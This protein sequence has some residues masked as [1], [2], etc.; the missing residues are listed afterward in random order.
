MHLDDCLLYESGELAG[1]EAAAFERHLGGCAECRELLA[2]AGA[3]HRWAAD[4]AI[5]PSP[6]LKARAQAAAGG[7]R[8]RGRA[9]AAAYALAGL[10]FALTLAQGLAPAGS[11]EDL[12]RLRAEIAR[13]KE[14][15]HE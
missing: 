2:A 15:S 8:A 12:E 11:R 7:V 4:A 9:A 3:A 13:L 14:S 6:S 10:L 5:E 1:A